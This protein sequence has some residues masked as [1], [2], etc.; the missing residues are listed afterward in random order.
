MD[1]EVF[2]QG[3]S[4]LVKWFK[5]KL[6]NEQVDVYFN[7]LDYI[8]NIAFLD[9]VKG[10][11]N[12]TKP[13]PSLFPTINDLKSGWW[14]WQ[15]D[16]PDMVKKPKKVDCNECAGSG[17][18]WFKPPAE[19]GCYPYEYIIGCENCHNRQVDIGTKRR[20]PLSSRDKLEAKGCEVY[21]YKYQSKKTYNSIEEMTQDIGEETPF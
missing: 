3:I 16:N 18:L 21:P 11:I 10:L 14:K 4:N 2:E 12:N 17:W 9:I 6:D 13:N 7:R 8:P 5:K 1:Y 19:E 20:I 15:Q